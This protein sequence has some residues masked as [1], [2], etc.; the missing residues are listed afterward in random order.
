MSSAFWVLI[1]SIGARSSFMSWLT[2]EAVSMPL[3]RPLNVTAG[4]AVVFVL[5]RGP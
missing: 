3:P 4:V 2:I 5:I 1:L